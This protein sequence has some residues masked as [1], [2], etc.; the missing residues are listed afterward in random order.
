MPK[1]IL[2]SEFSGIIFFIVRNNLGSIN[3]DS[4]LSPIAPPGDSHTGVCDATIQ[5]GKS[6]FGHKDLK[7]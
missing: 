7:T 6:I 4:L 3:L 2:N 1:S 5:P